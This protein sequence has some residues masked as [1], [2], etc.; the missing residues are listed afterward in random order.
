MAWRW[1]TDANIT[2]WCGLCA[3]PPNEQVSALDPVKPDPEFTEVDDEI[4]F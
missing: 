1:L 2:G 4:T 3:T